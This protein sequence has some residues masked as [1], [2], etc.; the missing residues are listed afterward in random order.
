[1][2]EETIFDLE[3]TSHHPTPTVAAPK[4]RSIEYLRL[5]VLLACER[6]FEEPFKFNWDMFQGHV[7]KI[8]TDMAALSGIIDTQKKTPFLYLAQTYA[9]KED[10]ELDECGNF[11]S[12]TRITNRTIQYIEKI[13][14]LSENQTK[15]RIENPYFTLMPSDST[16]KIQHSLNAAATEKLSSKESLSNPIIQISQSVPDSKSANSQKFSTEVKNQKNFKELSMTKTS[17]SKISPIELSN[18]KHRSHPLPDPMSH[19]QESSQKF[20]GASKPITIKEKPSSVVSYLS[21]WL[22]PKKLDQPTHPEGSP[23]PT[24]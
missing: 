21:S 1:M 20:F 6:P 7:K 23:S 16:Q 12:F 9:P 8:D 10:V 17:S 22:T 13:Y 4:K 11:V 15:E 18:K 3:L 2:Q 14:P 19:P 24:P 5:F